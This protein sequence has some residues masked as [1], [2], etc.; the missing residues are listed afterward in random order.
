MLNVAD[1]QPMVFS[2][3]DTV[4]WG[5][6]IEYVGATWTT[7]EASKVGI[8]IEG[9]KVHGGMEDGVVDYSVNFTMFDVV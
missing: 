4:V 1:G 5:S 3:V 6:T 8:E 9:I 2:L 7:Y